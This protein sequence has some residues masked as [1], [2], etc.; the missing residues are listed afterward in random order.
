MYFDLPPPRDF[1]K[2]WLLLEMILFFTDIIGIIH[3]IDRLGPIIY[4]DYSFFR[5]SQ[6]TV[7]IYAP[8]FY[9]VLPFPHK[10]RSIFTLFIQFIYIIAFLDSFMVYCT[11]QY[12]LTLGPSPYYHAY[13]YLFIMYYCG[14]RTDIPQN[15]IHL[16]QFLPSPAGKFGERGRKYEYQLETAGGFCYHS[17]M[18]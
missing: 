16:S 13:I 5:Y 10:N 1:V 8:V 12:R 9:S 2:V 15:S 14:L 6:H 7:S 4:E 18:R 3:A 17:G 11:F